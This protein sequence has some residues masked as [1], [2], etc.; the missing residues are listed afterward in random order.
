MTTINRTLLLP[1]RDSFQSSIPLTSTPKSSRKSSYSP[2]L[3]STLSSSKHS[4]SQKMDL[5]ISAITQTMHRNKATLPRRPLPRHSSKRIQLKYILY[6]TRAM[7]ARLTK[8]SSHQLKIY[9]IWG[10]DFIW[11]FFFSNKNFITN[12]RIS[13]V[14]LLYINNHSRGIFHWRQCFHHRS[15]SFSLFNW[16]VLN[17]PWKTVSN[18]RLSLES[19]VCFE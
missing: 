6:A 14:G 5:S 9:L 16:S 18:H 1:T 11:Y 3:S 10:N 8:P 7:K 15:S 19:N 13:S 4:S 17:L 12:D 2:P